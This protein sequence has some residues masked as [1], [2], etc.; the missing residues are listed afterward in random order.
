MPLPVRAETS[1][2][3]AFYNGVMGGFARISCTHRPGSA[4]FFS[5]KRL[6][7]T[8]FFTA[9]VYEE[10]SCVSMEFDQKIWGALPIIVRVMYRFGSLFD[11]SAHFLLIYPPRRPFSEAFRQT[12]P[13]RL[14]S[15]SLILRIPK[16]L[17]LLVPTCA[18]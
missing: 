5:E 18:L 3:N 6:I 17:C 16:A 14:K 2:F 11:K 10:G 8:S 1:H 4:G 9:G 15:A 12:Y 7:R 13:S